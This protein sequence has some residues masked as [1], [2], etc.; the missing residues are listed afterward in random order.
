VKNGD[1]SIDFSVHRAGDSPTGTDRENRLI[2]QDTGS[3]DKPVLLWLQLPGET[4]VVV[5]E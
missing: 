5:Q 4:G 3:R 2:N 1:I